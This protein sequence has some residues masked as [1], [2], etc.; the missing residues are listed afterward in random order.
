MFSSSAFS[1]LVS[2]R[3]F[4]MRTEIA[5]LMVLMFS[6]MAALGCTRQEGPPEIRAIADFPFDPERSHEGDFVSTGGWTQLSENLYRL[7]D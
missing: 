1:A 2:E 4:K 3:S 5:V 7:E 6:L